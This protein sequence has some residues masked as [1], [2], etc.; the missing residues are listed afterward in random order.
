MACDD[1][2]GKTEYRVLTYY[3]ARMNVITRLSFAATGTISTQTGI[4]PR[5]IKRAR[6]GLE[7]LGWLVP[8]H[9]IHGV[10]AYTVQ[11]PEELARAPKSDP[12]WKPSPEIVPATASNMTPLIPVA[13]PA[14][15]VAE[16]ATIPVADID[17]I[18]VATPCLDGGAICPTEQKLTNKREQKDRT[19]TDFET[20]YLGP[21]IGKLSGG[22][23]S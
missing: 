5:H 16:M 2:L 7:G 4:D 23:N 9:F 17:P 21:L 22:P 12:R 6:S 10:R 8:K 20:R 13:F 19:T 11:V 3:A 14:T 15:G 1:R 18:A